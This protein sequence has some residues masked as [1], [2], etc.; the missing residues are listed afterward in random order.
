[1]TAK[2]EQDLGDIKDKIGSLG[3]TIQK[4]EEGIMAASEEIKSMEVQIKK[5]SEVR[6]AENT[7]FQEEVTDQRAMQN[8]L[9]KAVARMRMVYKKQEAFAQ[10]DPEPPAQFQPYKQ[11]AG[12]S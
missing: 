6:E 12:A 9:K 11:S 8:I 4:M 5:A 10:Q 1:M 7:N 3:A 2:S